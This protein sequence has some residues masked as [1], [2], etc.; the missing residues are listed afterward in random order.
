MDL[1]DFKQC[2]GTI[3]NTISVSSRM[4][5]IASDMSL[6]SGNWSIVKTTSI[7]TTLGNGQPF[8]SIGLTTVGSVAQSLSGEI[9]AEPVLI[10]WQKSD[11]P[12][13]PSKYAAEVAASIGIMS[14]ADSKF[15]S[16][17]AIEQQHFSGGNA[18]ISKGE[19]TGIVVGTIFFALLLGGSILL[20]LQRRRQKRRLPD[21]PEMTGHTLGLKRFMAGKW[22]AEADAKTAPT[23]IDSRSVRVIPGPPVELEGS[24]VN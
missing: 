1:F 3:S 21:L 14:S 10:Y 15:S 18:R 4:S 17:S 5:S 13:F 23:E 16:T 9:W 2:Q 12:S 11:L 22:R 7:T 8:I 6:I 20:L 24:Q 19:I